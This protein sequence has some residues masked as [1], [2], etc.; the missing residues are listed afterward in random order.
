MDHLVLSNG[1]EMLHSELAARLAT[2]VLELRLDEERYLA[3]GVPPEERRR[4]ATCPGM[5]PDKLTS[6]DFG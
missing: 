1:L 5:K 3:A 2:S 4:A 6:L